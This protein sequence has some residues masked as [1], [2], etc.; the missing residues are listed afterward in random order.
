[1]GIIDHRTII[2]TSAYLYINVN[3][4]YYIHIFEKKRFFFFILEILMLAIIV[5]IMKS[6][7]TIKFHLFDTISIVSFQG[8]HYMCDRV[9]YE[10]YYLVVESIILITI[11][12][13]IH[14][15]L[16]KRVFF[17]FF[18]NSQLRSFF[19]GFLVLDFHG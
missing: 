8:R 14:F 5:I 19:F 7:D 2:Q 1:M 4:Y 10:K 9:E 6:N 18:E 12:P 17:F 13:I 11:C 3:I 16:K 15:A